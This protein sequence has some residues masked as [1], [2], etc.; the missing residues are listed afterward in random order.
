MNCMIKN[1]AMAKPIKYSKSIRIEENGITKEVTISQLD[2]GWLVEVHKSWEEPEK[3]Y[4]HETKKYAYDH[5]PLD[6]K[7]EKKEPE[8]ESDKLA[9]FFDAQFDFGIGYNM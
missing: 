2:K 5:N 9:K 6:T 3:G 1:N 8:K 4:Q 7:Q